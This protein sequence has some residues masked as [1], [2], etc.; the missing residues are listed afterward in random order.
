MCSEQFELLP[1]K[2]G[3]ATVCPKCSRPKPLDPKV[4]R[5]AERQRKRG[6]IQEAINFE[7][8]A[9]REAVAKGK[10]GTAEELEAKIQRLSRIKAGLR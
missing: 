9:K 5:E 1:G 7:I 3:L 8:R 10:L 2:P 4:A 6:A